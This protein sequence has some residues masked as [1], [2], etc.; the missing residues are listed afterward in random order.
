MGDG[1]PAMPVFGLVLMAATATS[2][3]LIVV[4]RPLLARYALARPNARSSHREPTPQ[5]GGIAVVAA[6]LVGRWVP[7]FAWLFKLAWFVGFGVAA[8]AY[9]LLMGAAPRIGG[10]TPLAQ[11]IKVKG[12]DKVLD[13]A[14]GSSAGMSRREPLQPAR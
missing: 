3:G 4:L 7:D 14:M 11:R 9:I 1:G 12:L 10:A 6:A 13:P 8:V 5:G 2:A